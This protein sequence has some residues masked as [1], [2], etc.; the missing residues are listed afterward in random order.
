MR[1]GLFVILLGLLFSLVVLY[2]TFQLVPLKELR[3]RARADRR[4]AAVYKSASFGGSLELVLGMMIGADALALVSWLYKVGWWL[5]LAGVWL[6][7]VLSRWQLSPSAGGWHWRLAAIVSPALAGLLN[8]IHPLTRRFDRFWPA[9]EQTSPSPL[10]EKEDLLELLER[11]KLQADSRLSEAELKLARGALVFGDKKVRDCLTLKKELKMVAADDAIGPHLMD[12]LHASGFTRFPVVKDQAK[13]SRDE[14]V[15]ILYLEDLMD[16]AEGGKVADIMVPKVHFINEASDLRQALS[17]FLKTRSHLLV[18][19][20]NFEEVV[21]VLTFEDLLEQILGEK[22]VD[23]FAEH[24]SLV[25]VASADTEKER[26]Q[27]PR[28]EVE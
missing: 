24:D 10:Y 9:A 14:I 11:Q 15:G 12:E 20:N 16:K 25:A 7:L 13:A 21:G 17:A 8:F 2:K 26:S 6:G 23:E 19:V 3:R 28:A 1:L 27:G 5:A 18:V 22:V 4:L